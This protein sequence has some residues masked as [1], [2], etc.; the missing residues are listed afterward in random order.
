[1]ALA[2]IWGFCE[3]DDPVWRATMRFAFQPARHIQ[4]WLVGH[5]TGQADAEAAAQQA[6]EASALW[7]GALPEASDPRSGRPRSRPW[8]AWPGATVSTVLLGG[9]SVPP[10]PSQ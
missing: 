7:D 2:P 10:P 1:M 9:T 6:L 3:P 4:N 5:A 8:F